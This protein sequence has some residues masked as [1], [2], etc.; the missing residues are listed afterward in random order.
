MTLKKE[1]AKTQRI[2][3]EYIRLRDLA[4]TVGGE[5]IAHCFTCG[6]MWHLDTKESKQDYHAMHYW[7]ERKKRN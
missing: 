2:V 3:N 5:K 6:K 1:L 4:K 7:R